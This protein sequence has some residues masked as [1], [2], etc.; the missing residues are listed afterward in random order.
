MLS[1]L[2]TDSLEWETPYG[3]NNKDD[4]GDIIND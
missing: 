4:E 3:G 2:I 1:E